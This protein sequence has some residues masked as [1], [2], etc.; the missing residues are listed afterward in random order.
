MKNG[1]Q[2]AEMSYDGVPDLLATLLEGRLDE[3]YHPSKCPQEWCRH[4]CTSSQ[5]TRIKEI[6]DTSSSNIT[7]LYLHIL[8]CPLRWWP[9]QV[10]YWHLRPTR[11]G[12][13]RSFRWPRR[14]S[15]ACYFCKGRLILTWVVVFTVITWG[16]CWKTILLIELWRWK[17]PTFTHVT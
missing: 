15:L 5:C 11:Q 6:L 16:S 7:W 8:Q 17:Y 10:S 2:T 1:P 4:Y 12:Q 3:F 14:Y 9:W 13:N